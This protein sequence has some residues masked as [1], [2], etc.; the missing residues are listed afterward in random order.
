MANF[1]YEYLIQKAKTVIGGCTAEENLDYQVEQ[2]IKE[3]RKEA[4]EK[5]TIGKE[6]Y[7]EFIKESD[8]KDV[9]I[10]WSRSRKIQLELNK[11]SHLTETEKEISDLKNEQKEAI[12]QSKEKIKYESE[13]N[14]QARQVAIELQGKQANDET[15]IKKF[16]DIWRNFFQPFSSSVKELEYENF[17][18][19]KIEQSVWQIKK[20]LIGLI[21]KPKEGHNYESMTCLVG[22]MNADEFKIGEHIDVTT[23]VDFLADDRKYQESA[24]DVTNTIFQ[25]ID[26]ELCRIT[27]EDR[28]FNVK[29]VSDIIKIIDEIIDDNNAKKYKQLNFNLMNPY[30]ALVTTHVVRYITIFLTRNEKDYIKRHS[31]KCRLENYKETALELFRG[32]VDKETEDMIAA[33]FFQNV[34]VEKVTQRVLD[35]KPLDVHSCML[36]KYSAKKCCVMKEVMKDLAKQK[37]FNNCFQYI[38][39]PISFVEKW[40][41]ENMLTTIFNKKQSGVSEYEQFANNYIRKIFEETKNKTQM[42]TQQCKD[43]SKLSIKEWIKRFCTNLS[44]SNILPVSEDLF[45]HVMKREKTDIFNFEATVMNKFNQIENVIRDKFRETT[46]QNVKWRKNP[47]SGVMRDLWGCKAKCPFCFEPCTNTNPNHYDEKIRHQCLQHRVQGLSGRHWVTSQKLIL[48][49]CNTGIQE[50]DFTFL[51]KE[52]RM[53][54]QNYQDLFPEWYIE[55]TMDTSKYWIWLLCHFKQEFETR[56]GKKF[57]D[58]PENWKQITEDEALESLEETDDF[59]S[60]CFPS[61]TGNHMKGEYISNAEL[62]GRT[63]QIWI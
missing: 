31:L 25:R 48:K 8:L 11:D 19:E 50:N 12:I 33:N 54:F 58:I 27:S 10:Q 44:S 5:L 40:L 6:N 37:D 16:E 55:P 49:F 42:T 63:Q 17:V 3:L 34:L 62:F 23:L 28:R 38:M 61:F 35:L 20:P 2:V 15:I 53:K 18:K 57:V 21:K 59:S 30:N 52:N 45:V 9:M 41:T 51:V 13:I 32:V 43:F 26:N 46:S 39:D 1:F 4:E 22:S 56:H 7:E 36:D 14:E 29:C 24:V 60:G 47:I